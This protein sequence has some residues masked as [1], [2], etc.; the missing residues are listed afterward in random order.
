MENSLDW[1]KKNKE[2][3]F[4]HHLY[5]EAFCSVDNCTTSDDDEVFRVIAQ[6]SYEAYM[7]DENG[8]GVSR[9]ADFLAIGYEKGKISLDD[10]RNAGKWDILNAVIEESYKYIQK[11]SC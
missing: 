11:E 2:A 10:I 9:I 7:K 5:C 3:F 1:Y 6:A 8:L 4:K